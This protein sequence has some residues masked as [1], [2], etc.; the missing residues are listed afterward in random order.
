MATKVSRPQPHGLWFAGVDEKP[1]LRNK[2][3]Y[4]RRIARI[5]DAVARI[6]ERHDQLRRTTRDLRKRAAK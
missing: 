5:L 4:T 2:D 1:G 3:E 6:R